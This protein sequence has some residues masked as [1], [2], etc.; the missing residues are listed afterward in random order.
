[1]KQGDWTTVDLMEWRDRC[2]FSSWAA[3]AGAI[4]VSFRMMKYY[5][6]GTWP[7]PKTVHLACLGYEVIKALGRSAGHLQPA[8][9]AKRR[10]PR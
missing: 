2:G 8:A 7:I 10:T 6:A 5:A 9:P 3:A 4:G 1:M